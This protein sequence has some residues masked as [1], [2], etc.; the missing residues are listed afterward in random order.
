MGVVLVILTIVES[1]LIWRRGAC[2]VQ[3]DRAAVILDLLHNQLH[4][5]GVAGILQE[6]LKVLGLVRCE[7][8]PGNQFVQELLKRLLLHLGEGFNIHRMCV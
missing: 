1:C 3:E 6:S 8:V 5:A 2:R 7:F 4:V